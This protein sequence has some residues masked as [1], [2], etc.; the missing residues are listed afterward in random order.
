MS[1]QSGVMT[2]LACIRVFIGADLATDKVDALAPLIAKVGS[3]FLDGRWKWPRRHAVA[4]PFAFL[5]TDPRVERLD[6]NDLRSMAAELQHRLFG[7]QGE[8]EVCLLMLEGDQAEIQRFA[9]A[10]RD[11]L[12]RLLQ[13]E[14]VGLDGR[15]TQIAPEGAR[16]LLPD[17]ERDGDAPP[18]RALRMPPK[19]KHLDPMLWR[20][21]YNCAKQVF[22]G[23]FVAT[24]EGRVAPDEERTQLWDMEGLL[25]TREALRGLKSGV[26]F[27]PISYSCLIRP[28]LRDGYLPALDAFD[29][30]DRPRLAATIY[31]VPRQPSFPA[32]RQIRTLTEPYF[33]YTDFQIT[34]PAFEMSHLPRETVSSVTLRLPTADRRDRL[35]AIRTFLSRNDA[36]RR[37]G[38]WQ[39]MTN[40]ETSEEIRLAVKGRAPF[41]SGPAISDQ[42]NVAIGGQAAELKHLPLHDRHRVL[43]LAS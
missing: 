32:L 29:P 14:D 7:D 2:A 26:L 9:A 36:F 38:V 37:A 12:S 4:A 24:Y 8:G 28:S 10:D 30:A 11:T 3:A 34:D 33:N 25:A 13:G 43:M 35:T 23:S 22:V 42:M 18:H 5:L 31:D 27:C 19:T 39:G 16:V 15:L 41:L 17:A 20:G 1:R 40:V 21:V 6:P